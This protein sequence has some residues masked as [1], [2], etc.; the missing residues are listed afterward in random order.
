MF[1]DWAGHIIVAVNYDENQNISTA[2]VRFYS[3]NGKLYIGTQRLNREAL[4][5]S[6]HDFDPLKL[7]YYSIDDDG[8]IPE[9]VNGF[10]NV[11]IPVLQLNDVSIFTVNGKEYIKNNSNKDAHDSLI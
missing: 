4:I 2:D 8:K 7:K 5:K 1:V 9:N 6:I 10:E 3:G 11:D